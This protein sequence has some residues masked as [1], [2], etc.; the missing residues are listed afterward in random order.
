MS[1][2]YNNA[3]YYRVLYGIN[4]T[5]TFH[6]LKDAQEFVAVAEMFNDTCVI[7]QCKRKYDGTFSWKCIYST[8]K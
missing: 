4:S 8:L 7:F 3:Y 5:K 2:N 1:N 6:S